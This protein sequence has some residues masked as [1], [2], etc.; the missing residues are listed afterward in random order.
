VRGLIGG[1][2]DNENLMTHEMVFGVVPLAQGISFSS[3]HDW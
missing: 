3:C 1:V 2:H